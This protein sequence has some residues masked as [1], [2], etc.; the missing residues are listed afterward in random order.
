MP[1]EHIARKISAEIPFG[2]HIHSDPG[3]DVVDNYQLKPISAL[4]E[5]GFELVAVL[6]NHT[7]GLSTGIFKRYIQ[8]DSID[9]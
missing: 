2:A 5:Q 3:L 4:E 8:E 7:G 9:L 1:W 6:P